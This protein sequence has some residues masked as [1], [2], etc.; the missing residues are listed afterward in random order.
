MPFIRTIK[1]GKK[2]Y[3]AIVKNFWDKRTKKHRQ[4]MVKWLGRT[5]ETVQQNDLVITMSCRS[6]EEKYLFGVLNR[7]RSLLLFGSGGV[8]KTFLAQR[9]CLLLTEAGKKVYYF[10]W[11]TPQG[12]FIKEL[13]R[14]LEIETQKGNGTRITQSQ[15]LKEIGTVLVQQ[16]AVLIIDKAHS[17]PVQLRNY[18][19]VWLEQTAVIL[20][21]GTLP[22]KKEMYL[23]FPRWELKPLDQVQSIKLVSASAR[24]YRVKLSQQQLRELAVRGNGN[25][26]FLIRSVI[27]WDVK[28]D[29]DPDQAEWI[30]LTPAVMVALCGIILLR[31]IGQGMSDKNLVVIG[32]M[33]AIAL[34]VAFILL[35]RMNKK[36]TRIGQR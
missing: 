17:I 7:R 35:S 15:L 6:S 1:R 23:K 10:P 28:G 27:D 32:G 4:R 33:A 5:G 24:H 9:V 36:H 25:P 22:P 20:L 31:F 3:R 11:T 34:R 18:I 26:Q 16:D 21:V 19:E 8:G 13:C 30:D 12:E 29:D 14:V 2:T